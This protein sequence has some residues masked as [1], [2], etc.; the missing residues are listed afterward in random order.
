MKDKYIIEKNVTF[1]SVGKKKISMSIFYGNESLRNTKIIEVYSE[2]NVTIYALN[3]KMIINVSDYFAKNMSVY[4]NGK[5][6]LYF[7][8]H[9]EGLHCK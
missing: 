8:E 2:P 6:L 3:K 1:Y 7:D 4:S 9:G 5:K